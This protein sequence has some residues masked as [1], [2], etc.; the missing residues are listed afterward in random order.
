MIFDE[1]YAFYRYTGGLKTFI[2]FSDCTSK[3]LHESTKYNLLGFRLTV[4]I[5]LALQSLMMMQTLVLKNDVVF[6]SNLTS[7]E[8]TAAYCL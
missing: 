8:Y 2:A 7:K 6:Y 5:T 4:L 1:L 3:L